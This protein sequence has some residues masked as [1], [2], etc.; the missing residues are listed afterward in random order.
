MCN[1]ETILIVGV[2]GLFWAF[3]MMVARRTLRP[4][5]FREGMWLV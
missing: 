3:L 1:A 4:C 5:L 2:F